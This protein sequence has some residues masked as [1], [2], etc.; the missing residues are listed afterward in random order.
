M[1]NFIL[2]GAAGYIA[3]RHFKAIQETGNNLIAAMDLSDSVGI[4]DRYF[5][6]ADFFSNFECLAEFIYDCKIQKTPID[7]LTIC[8][9]NYLHLPHMKFALYNG[10]NVICEKPLVLK[11]QHITELKNYEKIRGNRVNS[12][13]QLRLHEAILKLKTKF[14]NTS[15]TEY[16]VDLTYITSRGQWYLNSWKGAQN[17]SGGIATNIGIHFFDMLTFLFG[18]MKN[19]KV[20]TQSE[21]TA[22][23]TMILETAKVN[24]LL[25]IDPKNLPDTAIRNGKSTYRSIKINGEEIE[26]SEGFTDL[27]T[28]SYEHILSGNGF[29]LDDCQE[30]IRIAETVS[31]LPINART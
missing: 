3:E 8:S 6:N 26:F 10:L 5:P 13:L 21:K 9:P 12:I 23:G 25:S 31:N 28:R 18:S 27:H 15:P 2:V 4:I 1:K 17:K 7:Y 20:E 19:L 29:S 22:K 24:W 30:S 16:E 11:A 14:A